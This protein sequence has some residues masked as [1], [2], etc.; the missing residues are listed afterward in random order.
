MTEASGTVPRKDAT[1]LV[2]DRTLATIDVPE[3]AAEQRRIVEHRSGPLLVLGGPG[4]GKTTALVSA[5]AECVRT[6]FDPERVL[7]LTLGRTAVSDIRLALAA[8][9]PDA[10]IPKVRTWHGFAYS[11]VNADRTRRSSTADGLEQ[12]AT[13]GPLQ[14]L[15]GAEYESRIRELLLG[16][17]TDG[18][19]H[20][21][22]V[23]APA[24]TTRGFATDVRA[25][26]VKLRTL[27]LQPSDLVR[28]VEHAPADVP[29]DALLRETF[30]AAAEF[31][32]EAFD[33]FDFEGV[34]DHADVLHRAGVVM[35]SEVTNPY[36]A[37]YV[38]QGHDLDPAMA[39]LLH[40][41]AR[42]AIPVVIAADPDQ[43]TESFRGGEPQLLAQL[44]P[45]VFAVPVPTLTL[46]HDHVHHQA[47]RHVTT[48]L[49]SR[50]PAW[51]FD[52]DIVR[53]AR[54]GTTSL[55]G[56]VVRA[57]TFDSA[58]AEAAQIAELLVRR[59]GSGADELDWTDMAVI[60]HGPRAF[61]VLARAFAAAG[62]PFT[63][64]RDE[65]ALRDDPAVRVFLATLDL[66]LQ[67][68][69]GRRPDSE[70][71]R[72]FLLGPLVGL[73]AA[74]LRRL[75]RAFRA[76]AREA[77]DS[78]ASADDA[79]VT[80][81]LDRHLVIDVPDDEA[82]DAFIGAS[83]LVVATAAA[84]NARQP[85]SAVL[86]TV[87][88]SATSYADRLLNSALRGGSRGRRADR[89]LDAIM[90]LFDAAERADARYQGR[91]S[92]SA[93]LNEIKS[94][95]FATES[96]V[97]RGAPAPAV[98]LLTARR[99]RGQFWDLV[100]IP[101]L[102][103]GEWPMAASS[104][105]IV[106][107]DRLSSIGLVAPPT[108]AALL[109]D[110]RRVLHVAVS[111]AR[112]E[113]VITAVSSAT[114]DGAQPS[115]FFHEIVRSGVAGVATHT[116]GFPR[117]SLTPVGIVASIRRA[118]TDVEASQAVVSAAAV[119]LADLVHQTD[120]AGRPLFG[121]AHPQR[122]WGVHSVTQN[123]QPL[124][125]ATAPV[126]L[127][128][129]QLQA[130]EDCSLRR[131]FEKDAAAQRAS[132]PQASFGTVIHAVAEAFVN[133]ELP[134]EPDA[135]A[136]VIDAVWPHLAAD[137]QWAN[138]QERS[139]A[140]AIAD[141][142]L[143]WQLADRGRVTVAGEQNFDV[144]IE[145]PL[146][147]GMADSVRLVG[148]I[149]RVEVDASDPTGVHIVDFKTSRYAPVIKRLQEHPQLGVYRLIV[150][151]GA[152]DSLVPGAHVSGA[153]L[154]ELRIPDK[155]GEAKVYSVAG[156]TDDTWPT[157]IGMAVAALRNEE[158]VATP[159]QSVCRTCPV[160]RLC[161]AQPAGRQVL[162]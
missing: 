4:T 81:F 91:R 159:S 74:A 5:A 66:A 1:R 85:V 105:N 10:H 101:G 150:E 130:L 54:A 146:P 42:G 8:R 114:D 154:V 92:V 72:E 124:L 25:L 24:I 32:A 110:E 84:I 142:L 14:L 155:A 97:E 96:L 123:N 162:P 51:G 90:G 19:S 2:L 47:I 38:D 62:I 27:G 53:T 50:I 59:H 35:S 11:I 65:V 48:L 26:L 31:A 43:A 149:D 95:D 23:L 140:T 58:S 34:A 41:V 94:L 113:L 80:A 39:R 69:D 144:T 78:D 112:R 156:P 87:W 98:T 28:L 103:D 109:S 17:L 60:V 137:A 20:W 126:R 7:L 134:V 3:L 88:N 148:A 44:H 106:G 116:R 117:R 121:F 29:I 143:A 79:L 139:E 52:T 129:T 61:P 115:R 158:L 70:L 82:L 13:A 157:R 6:G 153:E 15:T 102:N 83:D 104:H 141:R 63:V 49:T 21:P 119:R 12:A 16:R 33:V 136:A 86:W 67:C 76:A 77:G 135:V 111:R 160:Q 108:R 152:V 125:D 133:D 64:P 57:A 138:D 45:Q 30:S 99:A 122:W 73:D 93:F 40:H 120:V 89:D 71:V 128:A 151:A 18:R 145:V 46:Q 22:A 161:P 132:T 147:D 127:S 36:D 37:I 131:F 118:G 100:V 55:G 56:G 75:A 68:S 9:L 107:A